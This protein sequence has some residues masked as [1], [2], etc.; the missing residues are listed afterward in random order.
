MA[1][2]FL[3]D[4]C[5][6]FHQPFTSSFF[7]D[8]FRQKLRTQAVSREKLQHTSTKKAARKMLVKLIPGPTII[9]FFYSFKH[10]HLKFVFTHGLKQICLFFQLSQILKLIS[11][12]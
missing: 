2:A 12:S 11:E 7:A 8:F 4:Q 6:Q 9:I 10:I 1:A 3:R 5:S